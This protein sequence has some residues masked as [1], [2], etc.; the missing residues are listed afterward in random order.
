MLRAGASRSGTNALW[1]RTRE[2]ALRILV[3]IAIKALSP[4]INRPDHGGACD[5]TRFIN[6]LLA[7]GRRQLDDGHARDREGKLRLVYSTPGWPDYVL[8]AVSEIR[9]YGAG[10]LQVN[11][12]LR[13]LLDHLMEALPEERRPS[14]REELRLR[15]VRSNADSATWKTRSVPGWKRLPRRRRQYPL[16]PSRSRLY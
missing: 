15:T 11:R 14:L 12:R 7:I 6:L 9:H 1:S 8:M 4:G 5:S 2:Y 3:D 10:S 16:T 13:A